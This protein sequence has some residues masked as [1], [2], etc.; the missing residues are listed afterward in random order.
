PSVR[1]SVRL[2]EAQSGTQL[3][4]G[5]FE[6]A[7]TDA[8]E[9]QD[10][11][12]PR[13]AEE[14]RGEV[15]LSAWRATTPPE[16]L[17][18]YRQAD[19]LLHG[20]FR[21]GHDGGPLALLD[22]C[23]EMAPDFPPA[24]ALH[25]IASLRALF[26]GMKDAQ[27]DSAALARASVDRAL[28]LAP[29]QATTHLA[30]AMLAAQSD[31]WRTAVTSLRTA[32]DI[33][34]CH[35]PTVQYLGSLQCEA[36]RADEGLV[37]L[38]LAY[39]LSPTLLSSL[40]ELARCS[41][42]RGQM[43]DYRWAMERLTAS[44]LHRTA[45]ESLRVRVA[46][47]TRDVEVLRRIKAESASDPDYIATMVGRYAS[48]VLGEL[49]ALE[50]LPMFDEALSQT[51]S[52][53]FASLLCQLATEIMGL[54]GQPEVGL[55][56]FRRAAETALI[57]LEWTDRCPALVA[58]RPLPGFAEGRRQVRARVEAIWHA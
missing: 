21:G 46:G 11:L 2:L 6:F 8:F 34:P 53:R 52:P 27:R 10:R 5:R 39:D 57:D 38:R 29:E 9:L 16:A 7:S 28:R 55:K 17:A 1:V 43:E 40:F 14:L 24:V 44:P 49:D 12:V 31:D 37:R 48:A 50:L 33:A 54:C 13:I 18:L 20:A 3:W 4:S 35:A 47:W 19:S 22:S 30:R 32:L 36:G 41:A 56:Y 42:L 26:M 25:A 58:L 45:A 23:L 15:V 51:N